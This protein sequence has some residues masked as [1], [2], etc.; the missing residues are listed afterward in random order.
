VLVWLVL[1]LS[2]SPRPEYVIKLP[3]N[4]H[5]D[6]DIYSVCSAV[7]STSTIT[8]TRMSV[9]GSDVKVNTLKVYALPFDLF[10]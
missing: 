6:S 10:L 9:R 1:M 8:T 4:T 2:D 3:L 5:S 7:T